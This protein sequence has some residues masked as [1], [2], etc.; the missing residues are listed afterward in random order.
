MNM[1]Q[2]IDEVIKYID[3]IGYDTDKVSASHILD[4][5]EDIKRR[6][7]LLSRVLMDIK[8][9]AKSHKRHERVDSLTNGFL[10]NDLE[11]IELGA[12]HGLRILTRAEGD[13]GR[14]YV[15]LYRSR[16]T[17]GLKNGSM[18]SFEKGEVVQC[19][20]KDD[21]I[22]DCVIDSEIMTHKEGEGDMTGYECILD[23]TLRKF[24]SRCR[25]VGWNGQVEDVSKA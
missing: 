18:V 9:D 16:F 7:N 22:E 11:S 23:G 20:N 5:L 1:T 19:L 3:E 4:I 25:I 14:T 21:A 8:H 17:P 24:V 13:S 10:I 2:R 15:P 6:D 12:S